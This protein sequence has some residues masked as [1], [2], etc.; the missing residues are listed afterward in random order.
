MISVSLSIIY[1]GLTLY[2]M[3]ILLRWLGPWLE[4]EFHG[5]FLGLLPKAT[6]PLVDFMKRVLP[7]MGPMDFSPMAAVMCVYIVR[8][9]LVRQ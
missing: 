5:P 6:D 4:L 7:N 1:C 8:L 3:A 9:I 2:M